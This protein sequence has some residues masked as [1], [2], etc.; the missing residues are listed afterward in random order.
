MDPPPDPQPLGATLLI[1]DCEYV[2]VK[3]GTPVCSKSANAAHLRSL[4]FTAAHLTCLVASDDPGRTAYIAWCTQASA[5]KLV[6]PALMASLLESA[7]P[8]PEPGIETVQLPDG[9]SFTIPTV[10]HATKPPS[11]KRKAATDVKRACDLLASGTFVL[12]DALLV[13]GKVHPDVK[14]VAFPADKPLAEALLAMQAPPGIE[15]LHAMARRAI[16][17]IAPE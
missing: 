17:G 6:T 14:R 8:M 9:R 15:E 1:D 13:G 2:V 4:D 10:P 12:D 3:L 5:Q 16:G 11:K 7:A